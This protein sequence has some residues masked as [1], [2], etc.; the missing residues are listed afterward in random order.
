MQVLESTDARIEQ[1]RQ[2]TVTKEYKLFDKIAELEKQ[3]NETKTTSHTLQ[4]GVHAKMT[5]IKTLRVALEKANVEKNRN[6]A[7]LHDALK[8]TKHSQRDAKLEKMIETQ[9]AVIRELRAEN[10]KLK[11][12]QFEHEG[13]LDTIEALSSSTKQKEM[14]RVI[15]EL[16]K[17]RNGFLCVINFLKVVFHP[18]QIELGRGHFLDTLISFTQHKQQIKV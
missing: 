9:S 14:Q 15:D 12:K 18:V 3:L 13:H 1:E 5:Q 2:D 8:S 6:R 17:E 16:M 4:Q 11:R 7:M 10:R